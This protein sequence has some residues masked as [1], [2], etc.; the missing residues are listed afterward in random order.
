M[1]HALG[2]LAGHSHRQKFSYVTHACLFSSRMDA[3]D[4]RVMQP[5]FLRIAESNMSDG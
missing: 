3:V 1:K 4:R 5:Q 2:A